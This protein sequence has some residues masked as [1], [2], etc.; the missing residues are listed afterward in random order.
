M[1]LCDEQN[2]TRLKGPPWGIPK[3][4][5]LPGDEQEIPR[6][7][8]GQKPEAARPSVAHASEKTDR[9]GGTSKASNQN[10]DVDVDVEFVNIPG[11]EHSK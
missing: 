2:E 8:P 7:T 3:I 4:Y 5:D 1:P 11:T 9:P 10:K 6:S